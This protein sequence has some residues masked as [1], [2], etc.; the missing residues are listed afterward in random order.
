MSL[1]VK[2]II[3]AII[4]VIIAAVVIFCITGD[5]KAGG[6]AALFGL[7]AAKK[8]KKLL[9][10]TAAA[11]GELKTERDKELEAIDQQAGE[12]TQELEDIQKIENES[13]RLAKLADFA[14][15]KR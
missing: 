14:N 12:E 5:L 13:E 6:L 7:P 15:R 3:A 11:S 9:E 8:A 10:E 2:L 4:L 1:K